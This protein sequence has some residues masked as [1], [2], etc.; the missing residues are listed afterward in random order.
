MARIKVPFIDVVATYRELKSEIDKAIQRVL[1][2]GWYILG[3]EVEAFENEFAM[4]CG[5][6]Y[7]IGVSSGLDA[8]HLVL[9]AWGISEGDEVIV[10]AHTFIATWLAVSHTGATPIP[11]DIDKR[12]YNID[13]NLIEQAI[14]SKT[15]VIIPVHLYGQPADMDSVNEIAQ[16][17]ELKV[18][19]DAAQAHGAKCKGKKCG[20]LG[21]AAGFSFYPVKN[22]GAFG[23]GGAVTTDDRNLA[24][25]IKKLRNYGSK[26][27][28][29]H[30]ELGFN[31]RLDEIQAAILRVKLR[32]LDERNEKRKYF[33]NYYF[34]NLYKIKGLIMPYVPD[35]ADPVWHLFVIRTENRDRLQKY[36]NENGVQVMIHYPVSPHE[37]MVYKGW[38]RVRLPI[39]KKINQ[40][41]LSLP[42]SHVLNKKEIMRVVDLI[43]SYQRNAQLSGIG[44]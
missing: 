20:S 9:R 38:S 5:I 14:T 13:P 16:K 3:N 15:K 31:N 27:K 4:Y 32:Y 11:V 41:V 18:L 21:D 39:T 26:E 44:I 24:E 2:S 37:Q 30:N 25:E 33:A 29:F 42:L 6:K 22:L 17:Y 19:E 28:Y 7:C 10:P 43:N 36:L 12:T 23:D 34:S 1:D 8:L 40:E 35:W